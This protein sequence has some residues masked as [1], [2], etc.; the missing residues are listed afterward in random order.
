MCCVAN[1]WGGGSGEGWLPLS[2]STA[3]GPTGFDATIP[4][5]DGWRRCM[6]LFFFLAPPVCNNRPE[7]CGDQTEAAAAILCAATAANTLFNCTTFG[8]VNLSTMLPLLQPLVMRTTNLNW[9][10]KKTLWSFIGHGDVIIP[11]YNIAGYMGYFTC[12]LFPGQI[13]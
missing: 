6:F 13:Q 1:L 5:G 4:V 12:F 10:K 11:K 3:G 8:C 2:A 7:I 9:A